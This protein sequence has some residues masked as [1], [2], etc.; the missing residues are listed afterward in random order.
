MPDTIYA[1]TRVHNQ[2]QNMLDRGDLERLIAAGTVG[3]A[4]RLLRDK[5]WGAQDMAEDADALIAFERA[6]AWALVEELAQDLKPF[7][8]FQIRAD[9]HNLKAAIKFSGARHAAGDAARYM[10]PGGAIAP[11]TFMKAAQEHDFSA[12]PPEMNETAHRAYEALVHAGG[13]Q[14]CDFILD[15]GALNALSVAGEASKSPL[16]RLFARV[17]VDGAVARIALRAARVGLGRDVLEIAIPAAG[18]LDRKAVIAAALNGPEAVL[19]A[20][21][22]TQ[23]AGAAAEGRVSFAALER[24][25]DDYLM[26]KLRPQR[27]VYDGVE[28]IAA[29]LIGREREIDA[30]RLI[31]ASK[32]N[33]IAGD[34]TQERL[35]ALY[36]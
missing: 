2:E 21:E 23:Y 28:P 20:L 31:L 26:E 24:W 7:D 16:M 10:L 8:L 12:L 14:I 35:R 36:V 22:S 32:A 27:H 17:T 11:E 9:Y 19:Q 3:E 34:R 13:G 18:S 33:H 6:R 4:L 1:V 15:A 5:G 29:Y 25:F 30:V